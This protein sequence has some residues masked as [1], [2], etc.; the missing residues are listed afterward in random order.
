MGPIAGSIDKQIQQQWWIDLPQHGLLRDVQ[1]TITSQQYDNIILDYHHQSGNDFF[2][3]F[4]Y[5]FVAQQHITLW[6][7][8]ARFEIIITNTGNQAMP[9]A[10]G[11]HTYF[12]I[13]SDDKSDISLSRDLSTQQKNTRLSGNDTI[14]ITNPDTLCLSTAPQSVYKIDYDSGFRHLWLRS[15]ADKNF[16]CIEPVTCNP[17]DFETQCWRLQPQESKKVWFEIQV[18]SIAQ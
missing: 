6:T 3:N 18:G 8:T 15:E 13:H 10:L 12:A 5:N 4:P 11:H 17:E 9:F 16:V 2:N 7:R 14:K 1:R